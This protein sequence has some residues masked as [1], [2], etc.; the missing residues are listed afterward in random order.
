MGVCLLLSPAK[1]LSQV[2]DAVAGEKTQVAFKAKTQSLVTY[3]QS[4]SM[5]T[6]ADV[7]GVSE[8]LAQ[9]N[10]DRYQNFKSTY[11]QAHA[12]Q[13]V[14]LF[15]G[16]VYR[17]L[18]ALSLSQESLSFAQSHCRILSGLYGMVRPLDMI[19]PYRLEM[20]TTLPSEAFKSLYDFWRK[21]VTDAL[22]KAFATDECT[23]INLASKEYAQVV[24]QAG[25]HMPWVDIVFKQTRKGATKT[26]ALL[27]KRARGQ[28]ARFIIEQQIK[29][30]ET[31]QHFSC[32]GYHFMPKESTGHQ[33]VFVTKEL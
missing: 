26:I 23:M 14:H 11:S 28:M 24:D 16:D 22:N 33:W 20:G 27:A 17:A 12:K 25:L 13:A 18:D 1:K 30:P 29:N 19:Q 7:F 32:D 9:L 31:I 2:S 8:R 10:Y 15:E 4:L 21:P 5:E 6:L 3:L